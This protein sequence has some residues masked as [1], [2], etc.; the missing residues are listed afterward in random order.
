ML[1][2]LMPTGCWEA[3]GLRP[4]LERVGASLL[5]FIYLP[6]VV[7]E[8]QAVRLHQVRRME[9]FCGLN[10]TL[11]SQVTDHTRREGMKGLQRVKWLPNS[12]RR[13]GLPRGQWSR[14]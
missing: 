1:F 12:Q 8:V 5:Q 2:M 7:D 13:R 3:W 4:N 14:T 10:F 11:R 6:V 9:M